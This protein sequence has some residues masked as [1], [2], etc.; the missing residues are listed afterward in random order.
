MYVCVWLV[1]LQQKYSINKE[2]RDYLHPGIN[3]SIIDLLCII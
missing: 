3:A 2:R 1:I